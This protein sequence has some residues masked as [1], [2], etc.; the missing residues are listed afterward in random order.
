MMAEV[1]DVNEIVGTTGQTSGIALK[2]MFTPMHERAEDMIVLLKQALRKRIKLLNAIAS[3]R[4]QQTIEN[5]LIQI[6]FRIPVNRIEEWANI[7]KLENVV[8]H[9]TMLKLLTDIEDPASEMEAIKN[10]TEEQGLEQRLTGAE[11][12]VGNNRELVER[13]DRQIKEK[14]DELIAGLEPVIISLG[15]RITEVLQT[16]LSRTNKPVN[17][18]RNRNRRDTDNNG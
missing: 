11:P 18:N 15:D 2:L 5:Y 6:Q 13:R 8:S 14:G 3:K 4:S 9:Q 16:A 7:S 12:G 1:P 10:E 17:R